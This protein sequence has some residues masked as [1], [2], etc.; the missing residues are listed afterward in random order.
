M[1]IITVNERTLEYCKKLEL[2][3]MFPKSLAYSNIDND[4]NFNIN[5]TENIP[6]TSKHRFKNIH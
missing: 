6:Q 5:N 3:D 2:K 1:E 4:I